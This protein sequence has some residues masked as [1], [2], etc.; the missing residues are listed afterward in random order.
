MLLQVHMAVEILLEGAEVSNGKVRTQILNEV[1][2][3]AEDDYVEVFGLCH[4]TFSLM[5]GGK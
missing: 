4:R 5:Y 2:I 3:T 1:C